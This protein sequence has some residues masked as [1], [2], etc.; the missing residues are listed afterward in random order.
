MSISETTPL[1]D[2]RRAVARFFGPQGAGT[3]TRRE[4][5]R[6]KLTFD[7]IEPRLLLNAD[8]AALAAAPPPPPPPPQAQ[9]I[10]VQVAV[11]TAA[12]ASAPLS[13][14]QGSASAAFNRFSSSD[15]YFA[16]P[17]AIGGTPDTG[18][19]PETGAAPEP[20]PSDAESSL[21]TAP[22]RSPW[23]SGK[24]FPSAPKDG[25]HNGGPSGEDLAEVSPGGTPAPIV[26]EKTIAETLALNAGEVS[27][28]GALQTRDTAANVQALTP[29]EIGA[30]AAKGVTRLTA[31]D[32]GVTLSAAQAIAL[33][34]AQ[35]AVSTPAGENVRISDTVANL[36]KLTS[37]QISKLSAI[38]ATEQVSRNGTDSYTALQ[39]RDTAA[40]VQALTPAEIGALAAKGVTR[41]TASDSGVTLS[42][43]QAIALETAQM[44]VSTPAGEHVRISDTAGN[45]QKLTSAQISKLSAIGATELFSRNGTVSYT[46]SQTSALTAGG[47]STTG[48]SRV[49]QNFDDG[50]FLVYRDGVLIQ[51]KSVLPGGGYLMYY[52]NLKGRDYTSISYLY[53]ESGTRIVT[54]LD[55]V[56]GSG[57]LRVLPSGATI[58]VGG[59]ILS[60]QT[61]D[62]QGEDGFSVKTRA[63]QTINISGTSDETVVFG[64]DFGQVT[65]IGF[66]ATSKNHALRFDSANFDYL[67]PEMTQ[68]QKVAALVDHGAIVQD[69]VNTRITDTH[70]NVVTLKGL[71]RRALLANQS[72]IAFS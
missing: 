6:Q 63:Q 7:C 56:D 55:N 27:G 41:L 24:G 47:V 40:H 10:V 51:Q 72:A 54:T 60:V 8:L 64:Q 23:G 50:S 52:G 43:A 62:R 33:E 1:S 66:R 29:A 9:E 32:S 49:I 48:T 36:Q 30:L 19:T 2:W 59:G 68:A 15:G 28:A 17:S 11:D 65:L 14:T 71:P 61:P 13:A 21:I 26:V 44:A 39:T 53:D 45:L 18:G 16:D 57:A 20:V 67:A 69:G 58:T 25:H 5:G 12:K 3:N 34:T 35:I 37:A 4:T 46:A 70:G 38:G 42:A 22:F 31:S